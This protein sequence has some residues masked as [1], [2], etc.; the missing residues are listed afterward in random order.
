MTCLILGERKSDPPP[1]CRKFTSSWLGWAARS[2][3]E[4]VACDPNGE[5]DHAGGIALGGH[6]KRGIVG[7]SLPYARASC[8]QDR[9]T[10]WNAPTSLASQR[11]RAAGCGRETALFS[12]VKI[13]HRT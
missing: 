10:R 12:Q 6:P 4:F 11:L 5:I 1:P 3:N 7:A 9:L 2:L 8:P 13:R